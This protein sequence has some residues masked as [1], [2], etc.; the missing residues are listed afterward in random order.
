[1]TTVPSSSE[2]SSLAELVGGVV[3]GTGERIQHVLTTARTDLQP[4]EFAWDRFSAAEQVEG[5]DVLVV[6]DTW[7]TGAKLQAAAAALKLAGARRVAGVA[8]GRWMNRDF[9]HNGRWID[10]AKRVRWS[11]D[12]CGSGTCYAPPF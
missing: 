7:T 5:R 10:A 4:R 11:W 6:D 9:K 8:I 2:R 3:V 1:M 12:N